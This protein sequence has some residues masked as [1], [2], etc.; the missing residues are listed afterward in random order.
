MQSTPPSGHDVEQQH[1]ITDEEDFPGG[2]VV[3]NL[4]PSA[5]VGSIP[6]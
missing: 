1:W 2:S 3:K 4:S 5:D 6:G